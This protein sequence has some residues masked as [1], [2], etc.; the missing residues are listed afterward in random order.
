MN[1]I[2]LIGNL[3]KDTDL[4]T[5]ANGISVCKFGLA[6]NRDKEETDFFNIVVFGDLGVSCSKYLRKGKKCAIIGKIQTRS[7]NDKDGNKKYITE[8]L[9]ES[10]E[11]LSKAESTNEG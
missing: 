4:T 11:F 9:A 3:T 8:V 10:V 5:T 6:V 2:I 7:Y 1:K